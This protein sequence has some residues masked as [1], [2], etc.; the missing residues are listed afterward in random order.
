M[1]KGAGKSIKSSGDFFD[2]PA[3]KKYFSPP[4]AAVAV[5]IPHAARFS[6]TSEKPGG[7]LYLYLK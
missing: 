3:P 1:S 6:S 2:L 7:V 5:A 4:Y